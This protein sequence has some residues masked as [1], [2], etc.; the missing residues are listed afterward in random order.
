MN[1]GGGGGVNG[2]WMQRRGCKKAWERGKGGGGDVGAK[3][4]PNL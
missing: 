3:E 1:G 2:K 4:M